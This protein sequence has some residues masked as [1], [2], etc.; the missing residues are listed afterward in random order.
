MKLLLL[1][2]CITAT[3]PTRWRKPSLRASRPQAYAVVSPVPTPSTLPAP[4]E[5]STLDGRTLF[6]AASGAL[7]GGLFGFGAGGPAGA[8]AGIFIGGLGGALIWTA[9][10]GGGP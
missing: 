6:F 3:E 10:T 1:L 4:E 2:A 8:A 7:I 9:R 5:R